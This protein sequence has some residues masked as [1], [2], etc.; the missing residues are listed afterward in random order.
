MICYIGGNAGDT[1]AGWGWLAKGEHEQG[2]VQ[3]RM[4]PDGSRFYGCWLDE[5]LGGSDIVF[6]RIMPEEFPVTTP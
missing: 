1:V 6:R 2:E 3:I 5:G 4:T